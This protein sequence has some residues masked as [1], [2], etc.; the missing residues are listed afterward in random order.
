MSKNP[1]FA[2]VG[3]PNEGKSSVL[4][5]LTEDDQ[6]VISPYPGETIVCQ[7][8][9]VQ[10][11]GETV[12][13]FVDTP[14][15][16]NPR[17]ILD[18]MHQCGKTDEALLDAFLHEHQDQPD[19]HHDCELMRPLKEGVGVIYVV[20]CS[21]PLLEEDEAEMEIL[22]L[23]NKPRMAV[24]NYKDNDLDYMDAW[25]TSFRRHF[26]VIREFN[27]HRAGYRER[28]ALLE[29]LKAI[30]QEWEPALE[31]AITAFR[32]DWEY[33]KKRVAEEI[34]TYLE[35]ALQHQA[36]KSY[37]SESEAERTKQTVLT[38]Y[39][40]DISKREQRLFQEVRRLYRHQVYDFRL[41]EHSILNE[42][43]FSEKTWQILGLTRK[44]LVLAAAGM[45]AGLG[46]ALDIAASGLTFGIFTS[47]GAVGAGGSAF[48]KGREL[49]RV[50]IK[51]IP[52]GG[53]KVMVGPNNNPQ[54]PFVLL[55]RAVLYY[56]AISTHAHGLRDKHPAAAADSSVLTDLS[57]GVR[58]DLAK[59]FAKLNSRSANTREENRYGLLQAILSILF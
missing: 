10:I 54:F 18:W 30:H 14:G 35:W 36:Q 29:T 50:R 32:D 45:G 53:S 23:I 13:E 15:F 34:V 26:N 6:V 41:P 24:I 31:R 8:F 33:R 42:D 12:L 47:I 58:H 11:N 40:S 49:S 48:F 17:K 7:R 9:P 44:Q 27:A 21:R 39:R 25:K 51:Q 56:R 52:L 19:Y 37:N 28:I 4:S 55:D 2:I 43:L 22:R 16:Q 38:A 1:V 46:A 59:Y 20:D 5:T 3:H 57:P